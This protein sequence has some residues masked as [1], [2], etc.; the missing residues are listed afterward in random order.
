MR[1]GETVPPPAAA[2]AALNEDERV[3]KLQETLARMD[4]TILRQGRQLREARAEVERLRGE[5]LSLLELLAR[6][7]KINE[8]NTALLTAA[9]E[10]R[11]E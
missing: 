8:A 9:K 6:E 11:D 10:Q 2:D 7:K 5:R 4:T 1:C 3:T